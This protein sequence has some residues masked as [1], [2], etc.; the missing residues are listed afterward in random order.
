MFKSIERG[1][2]DPMYDLK[3]SADEDVSAEKVD[4]GVGIYRNEEG[5]YQ[6]PKCIKDVSQLN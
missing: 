1:P 4:L 6:E 3:R 2:P 5:I